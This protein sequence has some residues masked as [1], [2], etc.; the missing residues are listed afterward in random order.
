MLSFTPLSSPDAVAAQPSALDARE[1]WASLRSR[2]ESIFASSC[3]ETE[4]QLELCRSSKPRPLDEQL[5]RVLELALRG[6]SQKFIGLELGRAPS[7]IALRL[8][9]ALESMGI[10]TG[11]AAMP[12]ALVYIAQVAW[13]TVPQLLGNIAPVPG[14]PAHRLISL[15]RPDPRAL[16]VLSPAEVEVVALLVEGKVRKQIAELRGTSKRTLANQLAD[17]YRKLHLTGRVPLLIRTLQANAH[18][19]LPQQ[20]LPTLRESC[21]AFA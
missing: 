12:T 9:R 8:R 18:R 2:K 16:E 3:T 5:S 1:L 14:K 17:I 7:T 13:G 19:E 11:S 10:R 21:S 15:R 4:C 6:H 20:A